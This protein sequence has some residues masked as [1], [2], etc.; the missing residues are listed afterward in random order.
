MNWTCAICGLKNFATVGTCRRCG[1]RTSAQ[2]RDREGPAAANNEVV[3]LERYVRSK[4][5][6]AL[7]MDPTNFLMGKLLLTDRR[8]VFLSTGVDTKTQDAVQEAIY[9]MFG[10]FGLIR[11]IRKIRR[12]EQRIREAAEYLDFTALENRGSWA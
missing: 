8:I 1:R 4:L 11:L 2:D 12:D 7:V 3:V 5:N 6:P 10:I 9:S